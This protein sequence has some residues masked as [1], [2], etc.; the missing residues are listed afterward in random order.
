MSNP[1]Q[2]SFVWQ[3]YHHDLEPNASLF[4]AREAC[5][6]RHIQL[7]EKTGHLM[8]INHHPEALTGAKAQITIYNL[9]GTVA[10]EKALDLEATPESASDYG[11][12]VLPGNLSPVYFVKL[13]LRDATGKLLSDNF[14]WQAA[15][16]RRD[17]LR[18]LGGLPSV[19]LDA[20]VARHDASGKCLLDVTLHNPSS[21]IALMA[22]LQLHRQHSGARV[23]PAYY[24]GNYLSLTPG[25]TKT[26]Q[27]EAAVADLKGEAPLIA[28]DGW[29][30]KVT[31]WKSSGASVALNQNAQVDHW[32]E[33]GL[34]IVPSTYVEASQPADGN[35]I[36]H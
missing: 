14:Y 15:T 1:A 6:P 16:D 11:P 23:L 18:D 4:A 27:I 10:S 26:I 33:T 5:E 9:D 13:E 36:K 7:N 20:K 3:I 21:Q 32:P 22:H 2:P 30:V 29:N 17:D 8:V 12:V 24:T 34:P 35:S 25:E 28:V 31:P 19:T